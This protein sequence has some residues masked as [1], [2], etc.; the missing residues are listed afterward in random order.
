MRNVK[1]RGWR[2]VLS[3]LPLTIITLA[4]NCPAFAATRTT[5]WN[6][7]VDASTDGR[8]SVAGLIR[9][10]KGNLYGTTSEGGAYC[11]AEG[12]FGEPGCG[13]VFELS[14]P[15][16]K[17]GPWTETIIWS[18][19]SYATDGYYPLAGLVMAK[20][21]NLYGTTQFGGAY[22]AYPSFGGTV[23]KLTPPP[24]SS[25]SWTESIIWSFGNGTDGE[26]P[27]A[28][29]FINSKGN[30]YGTTAIG[31][32]YYHA[33]ANGGTPGGAVFELSPPVTSGG[34]WTE[35]ILWSFGNEN[36]GSMP[37]AGLIVDKAGNLYGTTSEGGVYTTTV[38]N[39]VYGLGT[40]F[41][42]SP[43]AT[44]GGKWTE[45]VLW[46]FGNGADGNAPLASL[47]M[48]SG[49]N[50]Y[51]TTGNDGVY[52]GGTAFELSPP[53]TS[54]ANWTEAIL[55]DF[56]SG[57]DGAGPVAGLIMDS[58][59]NLYGTTAV[60]G[61]YG[62]TDTGGTAF[63][64]SPPATTGDNWNESILVNFG[65]NSSGNDPV[66]SL[67]MDPAHNLYGTTKSGGTHGGNGT[68]FRISNLG[69]P[70]PTP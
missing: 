14:P 51:G 50:L 58:Q 55:R 35:S 65:H 60:G 24:T 18:F 44:S 48:D 66:A 67:L 38:G 11:E 64:L 49:G 27:E 57:T 1:L 36:D 22:L 40:A 62:S 9:D 19:G 33:S 21:G 63:E 13:T 41:K 28:G 59:G 45:A 5:L 10:G 61:L 69:N 42:L 32:V 30:L 2:G 7:Q 16:T 70:T 20:A 31:G 3:L 68:V 8:H 6:F 4:V 17:G 34:N 37:V 39:F 52:D 56:G 54:G 46:D 26:M 29:L 25:G 53:A 43:P 15:A 47:I 23:F 12:G